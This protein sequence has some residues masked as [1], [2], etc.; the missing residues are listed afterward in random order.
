MLYAVPAVNRSP[1]IS[2]T[3]T[4][5][6]G[7]NKPPARKKSTDVVRSIFSSFF[8]LLYM[9]E[10][11]LYLLFQFEVFPKSLNTKRALTIVKNGEFGGT[12]TPKHHHGEMVEKYTKKIKNAK[13]GVAKKADNNK[14]FFYK[15]I[16]SFPPLLTLNLP[17]YLQLHNPS[18][19]FLININ[20]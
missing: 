14:V 10:G 16:P 19:V 2:S 9:R 20:N 5:Y 6:I 18:F 15:C 4:A 11:Y 13:C 7:P 12:E 8:I 17:P 1:P 3:K